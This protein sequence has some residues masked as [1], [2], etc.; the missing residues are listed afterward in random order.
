MLLSP[1]SWK[2]RAARALGWGT[3]LPYRLR[4]SRIQIGLGLL[5]NGRLRIEGLQ[6]VQ[7]PALQ[8]ESG[9][10]GLLIASPLPGP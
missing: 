4:G 10:V 1:M 9:L 5:G 6:P 7:Q 8:V 3:T 2:V